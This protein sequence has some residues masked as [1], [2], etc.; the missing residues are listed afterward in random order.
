MIFATEDV[1]D[2]CELVYVF[3]VS[4]SPAKTYCEN[5]S[6]CVFVPVE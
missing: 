4:G 2:G 6:N 5:H 1:F 3:G